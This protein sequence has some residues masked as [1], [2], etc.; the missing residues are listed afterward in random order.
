M[1]RNQLIGVR[2][3]KKTIERLD[4]YTKGSGITKIDLIR[5]AIEEFLDTADEAYE[6]EAVKDYIQGIITAKKF[7]EVTGDEPGQDLNKL[8]QENLAKLSEGRKKQ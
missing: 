7:K 4:F 1:A 3:E 6:K 5:Q 2:L 8:R